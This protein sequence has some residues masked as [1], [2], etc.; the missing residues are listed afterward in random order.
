MVD[1]DED[2]QTEDLLRALGIVAVQTPVVIWKGQ[3]ILPNP[4]NTDV[5]RAGCGSRSVTAAVRR[6][7]LSRAAGHRRA[8]IRP[9]RPA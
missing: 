3:R 6:C 7:R 2:A 1:L 4:S 5:R 8:A 9:Q